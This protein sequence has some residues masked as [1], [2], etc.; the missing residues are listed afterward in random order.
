MARQ[1]KDFTGPKT[2]PDS[3]NTLGKNPKGNYQSH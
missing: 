3:E 2:K 1:D